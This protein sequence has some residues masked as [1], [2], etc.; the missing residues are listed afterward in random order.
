MI[1]NVPSP[2]FKL[3]TQCRANGP[4]G[5]PLLSDGWYVRRS[6]KTREAA[7]VSCWKGPPLNQMCYGGCTFPQGRGVGC[8]VLSLSTP[9]MAGTKGGSMISEG[10]GGR[11][12]WLWGLPFLLLSTAAEQATLSPCMCRTQPCTR[13]PCSSLQ[14]VSS[15][16]NKYLHLSISPFWNT[17]L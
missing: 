16:E 3:S 9:M 10:D 13:L 1:R 12:R 5:S 11:C 6:A 17:C 7:M 15:I 4:V 8:Y 14:T 2:E